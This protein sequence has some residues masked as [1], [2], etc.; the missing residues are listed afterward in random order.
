M[1]I[2]V[3]NIQLMQGF[4]TVFTDKRIMAH[5]MREGGAISFII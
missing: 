1:T 5:L 2:V 4:G 3:M